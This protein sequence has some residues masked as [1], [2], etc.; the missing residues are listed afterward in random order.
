MEVLV[1]MEPACELSFL[2]LRALKS[3]KIYVLFAPFQDFE[4]GLNFMMRL[5]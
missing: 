5:R 4:G 3:S 1:I 2:L